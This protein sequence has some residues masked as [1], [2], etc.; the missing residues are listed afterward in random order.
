MFRMFAG[1]VFVC[2]VA[3]TTVH[4]QSAFNP[5]I[6]HDWTGLNVNPLHRPDDPNQISKVV[7]RFT[8]LPHDVADELSQ[9]MIANVD[10]R[11]S[12]LCIGDTIPGMSFAD[13]V[14]WNGTVQVKWKNRRDCT[15]TTEFDVSR[16]TPK[17]T[18]VYTAFRVH[19]CK[20]IGIRWIG[21]TPA[22]PVLSGPDYSGI[23]RVECPPIN[24]IQ[25]SCC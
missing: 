9:K 16:L 3:T 12:T 1:I 24:G 19:A 7:H 4:A 2:L 6:H 15:P 25:P 10:G 5:N 22:P 11:P 13:A 20:N 17:G 18:E 14:V 23:P 8:Y 21:L